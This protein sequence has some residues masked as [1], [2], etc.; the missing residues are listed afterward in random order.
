MWPTILGFKRGWILSEKST[1][2][3][4]KIH[5]KEKKKG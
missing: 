1:N 3:T 4:P 2:K 5:K